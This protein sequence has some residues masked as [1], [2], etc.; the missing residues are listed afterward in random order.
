MDVADMSSSDFTFEGEEHNALDDA[1]HQARYVSKAWQH[2]R[3]FK[4]QIKC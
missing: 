3:Q 2:I 1:V 4:K